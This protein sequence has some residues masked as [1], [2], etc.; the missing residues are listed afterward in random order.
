MSLLMNANGA[1]KICDFCELLER[2]P[3][4]IVCVKDAYTHKKQ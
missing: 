1:F 3:L 4:G 2:S